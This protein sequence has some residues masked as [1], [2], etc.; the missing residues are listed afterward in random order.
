M[1]GDPFIHKLKYNQFLL[2][3]KIENIFIFPFILLGRLIAKF[4]PLHREYEVFFFFPFYHI[5]GAEK[6]HYQIAGARGNNNC[7]IYFTRK[8]NNDL[9]YR[10]FERSG[11]TMKDISKWTDN[12]FLYFNNLVS[13]G[14]ISYYIN[15]QKQK[16]VVFNGQCNFGYKISPWINKDIPQLELIHSLCSFS[17]IR[18]PFIQFYYRTIMISKKRI[19]DHERLY[20]RFHIPG[21]FKNNINFILNGVPIP[22]ETKTFHQT[23]LSTLNVL[24]VGR[25]TEEKRVHLIAAVAKEITGTRKINAK[26]SFMGDVANAIPTELHPYC[27][28]LGNQSD[29]AAIHNIYLQN[30]ILLMLSTTEGFPMAI[31]EAMARGLA[32]VSTDVGEI[33][34]HV[35]N[36]VNGYLIREIENDNEVLQHAVN[37]ISELALDHKLLQQMGINN[38]AHARA[39]FSLEKFNESYRQLFREAKSHYA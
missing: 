34:R 6:V 14:I 36:A 4:N 21:H 31:M 10:Y 27:T 13:R 28:F 16:P 38:V 35:K 3:R 18:I 12:K 33:S 37:R 9:Y 26:F 2:K 5:G 20:D 1:I 11:C 8:S 25:D 19:E 29:E 15:R 24:Y 22:S 23:A 17:Y 32:I 30:N 39:E 7:I